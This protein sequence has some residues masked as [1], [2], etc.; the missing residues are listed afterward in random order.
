MSF[1]KVPLSDGEALRYLS[2]IV[3]IATTTD[4]LWR[5]LSRTAF[6]AF[7]ETL[8]RKSLPVYVAH[9][10]VVEGMG[11]LAAKWSGMGRWQITFGLASILILWLFALLLDVYK[12]PRHSQ[13]PSR[14]AVAGMARG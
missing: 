13:Q 11:I 7:V 5:S 2:M 9:L 10:W 6:A 3:G 1:A 4:L 12:Q 14:W 8:G